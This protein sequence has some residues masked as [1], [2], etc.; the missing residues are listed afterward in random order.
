[1]KLRKRSYLAILCLTLPLG[2]SARPVSHLVCHFDGE[3]KRQSAA[4]RQGMADSTIKFESNG[5]CAQANA[6]VDS[7]NNLTFFGFI[8]DCNGRVLVASPIRDRYPNQ[9]SISHVPGRGPDLYQLHCQADMTGS[10]PINGIP[11]PAVSC[12]PNQIYC[13]STGQCQGYWLLCH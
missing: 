4:Q 6:Y 9:I 5:L 11:D 10:G 12:R 13:P 1:M 3:E 7:Q 8:H 2:A